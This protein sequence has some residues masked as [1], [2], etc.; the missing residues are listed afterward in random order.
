MKS[1]NCK[2][3]LGKY[4]FFQAESI[5]ITSDRN[6][7]GDSCSLQLPK[8]IR[9]G[10]RNLSLEHKDVLKIGTEVQVSLG[11]DDKLTEK[12]RGYITKVELDDIV[13]ITCED[14]VKLLKDSRFEDFSLDDKSSLNDF[15]GKVMPDSSLLGF[16]PPMPISLGKM[17]VKANSAAEGLKMF[18]NKTGFQLFF[19]KNKLDFAT[20]LS[21]PNKTHVL[22]KEKNVASTNFEKIKAE[23]VNKVIELVITDDKNNGFKIPLGSK[24]GE[25]KKIEYHFS[26][27]GPD[28]IKSALLSTISG[29]NHLINEQYDGAKGTIT[30]FGSPDVEHGDAINY[31]DPEFPELNG[32]YW[33]SSV[34]TNFSQSGIR[35][36]LSLGRDVNFKLPF[37]PLSVLGQIGLEN[38]QGVGKELIGQLLKDAAKKLGL[39]IPT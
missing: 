22:H 38:L 25:V 15:L 17:R 31:T 19:R 37:D 16:L 8:Q 7:L 14:N 36:E 28:N 24:G 30:I 10:K 33:V 11:Y 34:K 21:R 6:S 1:I 20:H 27:F 3:K 23:D 39:P 18:K 26:E 29:I 32:E 35:Q 12:F 9:W 5:E 4:E 2:I 13:S